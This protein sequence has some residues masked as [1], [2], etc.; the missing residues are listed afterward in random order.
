MPPESHLILFVRHLLANIPI[1]D[2]A[3]PRI[4]YIMVRKVGEGGG[5][6]REEVYRRVV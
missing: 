3:F 2:K 6:A 5:G 1:G 4:N